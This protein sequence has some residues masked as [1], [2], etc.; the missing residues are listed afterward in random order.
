MNILNNWLFWTLSYLIAAVLFAQTF[1]RANRN[2]K[3]A[4][5]LT[6]L[7]EI[8]TAL[9]ALL[10]IPL[11]ELKFSNNIMTYIVL[12][13]VSIIYAITDRLNIEARYGLDPS[14]F[15]ML[16]QMSTVFIIVLG[17]IFMK[18][19][20]VLNKIIGAIII[21]LANLLLTFNKNKIKVNK[22]FVM[23]FISNFLFAILMII[24][25]N[26][27]SEFNIAFY[28]FLT[29]FTPSLIIKIFGRY[30]YIDLKNEFNLYNKKLFILS[31]LFWCIM[32][33]S[34]VKAYEFGSIIIVASLFAL[35]SLL[36]SLIEFI[37]NKNR[38]E[39]LKKV[40][41]SILIIIGVILIK[42]N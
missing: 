24:N 27:S 30:K 17:I 38:K 11:F 35:T 28:T 6:I 36:N 9:F 20:V 12:L 2:M 26:I 8:F 29:V 31:G 5:L 40:I 22:Y 1:K 7:L 33:I 4:S 42:S 34:S 21:I 15:S 18:E 19:D 32:L 25:I 10:L 13:L 16:K 14:V 23:S 3:N 37:F 41:V 39:L